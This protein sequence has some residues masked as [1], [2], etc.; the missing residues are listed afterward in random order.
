M[1]YTHEKFLLDMGFKY[2]PNAAKYC[3][4][5]K[6][7]TVDSTFGKGC[8]WFYDID[9]YTL[10][11]HDFTFNN[12]MVIE[13]NI[14][15]RDTV[16]I[17]IIISGAGEI[18]EPYTTL[19]AHSL[20]AYSQKENKH[21]RALMHKGMPFLSVGFE[22]KSHFINKLIPEKFGIDNVDIQKAIKDINNHG[23]LPEAERIANQILCYKGSDIEAKL[24]F[25]AK[26]EEVLSL[27][28]GKYISRKKSKFKIYKA[29]FDAIESVKHYIDDHYSSSI[30]QDLLCQI[31]L[32]GK[33]KLKSTFKASCGLSITEYIQLKRI[34]A[35]E[36]LIMNTDLSIANISKAVGYNSA[37]R[38]AK[39]FF[40]YKG[41]LPGDFRRITKK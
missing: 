36:H 9:D 7:Y 17:S 19:E 27:L 12:D 6:T 34:N 18:C 2:A 26:A 30:A 28:V 3:R 41:I 31:A 10:N 29:D 25:D 20:F 13:S 16:S 1:T 35:A 21:F 24:F 23:K 8:Y 5:G 37:S 38:F 40:R 22:Y 33:T 11:I 14:D 15:Y 39:L 4:L 32:M